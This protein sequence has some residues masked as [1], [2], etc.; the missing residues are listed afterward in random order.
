MKLYVIATKKRRL[1]YQA[2]Y[3]RITA[4]TY[5]QLIIAIYYYVPLQS[6]FIKLYMDDDRDN[7]A[8]VSIRRHLMDTSTRVE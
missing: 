4:T 6:L 1:L 8:V 5:T 7:R 2:Y 3:R